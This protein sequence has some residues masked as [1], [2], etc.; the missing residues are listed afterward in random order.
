MPVAREAAQALNDEWKRGAQ[1]DL[2]ALARNVDRLLDEVK[3]P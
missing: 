3:R 2:V 1:G